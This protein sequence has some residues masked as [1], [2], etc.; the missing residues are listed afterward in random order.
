LVWTIFVT[1]TLLG[2]KREEPEEQPPAPLELDDA[3]EALARQ[4]CAG[5]YQCSCPANGEFASEAE[6]VD[7]LD[8]DL[9]ASIDTWLDAGASWNADCAGQMLAAWSTWEC[10]GP[11]LARREAAY[12]PRVCPIVKGNRPV[13]SDCSTSQIGDDC[14]E[15][16]VC[17]SGVCV[18][19]VVPVPIGDVCEYD[20]QELPCAADSW[21]AYDD[22]SEQRICQPLPSVGDSCDWSEGYLC[23][24]GSL[25][26]VCNGETLICEPG[27]AVGEPCFEG[28][29]CGP[30]LYC[31]GGKDFTCQ[32]RFEI[33]DGCGA[34]A[35]CPI[36]A[37][38]IAN[39]CQA[40][41]PAA[42][43]LIAFGF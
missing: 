6:C 7:Q 37:S 27:P 23:G 42:C 25:D 8:S 9:Q 10:L 43:N 2:C 17:I 24:P 11:G 29:A 40:D 18:E 15:G 41:P 12:D 28:I 4:I 31:D 1:A 33:G 5:F 32:E 26:L 39:V 22:N 30:G 20:W 14:A 16:L 38:C 36:D 21:C 19:T 13:G 35:V 34:D 3:A